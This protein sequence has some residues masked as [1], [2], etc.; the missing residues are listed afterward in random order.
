MK[1]PS[2]L[3]AVRIVAKQILGAQVIAD[4]RKRLVQPAVAYVEILAAGLFG[5]GD[6]RVLSARVAPGAG[7]DGH[8][9]NRVDHYFV[10]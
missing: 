8:I 9:D 3:L 10:A 1:D 5:Q 7:L 4:F 2:R 6:Q